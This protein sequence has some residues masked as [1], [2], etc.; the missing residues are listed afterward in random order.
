M[1]PLLIVS[2]ATLAMLL[3]SKALAADCI[4]T[5]PADFGAVPDDDNPDTRQLQAAIDATPSG[6]TLCLPRGHLRVQR[7]GAGAWNR[8]AAVSTHHKGLSVIGVPGESFVD[9][10]GDQGLGSTILWSID[11]GAENITFDGVTLT[12]TGAWNTDEQTH[13]WATTG[14]CSA[15][16]GTC[17][18]IRNLTIRNSVC[19]HP[20][21][22]TRRGDCIRLLGNDL[23]T[24]VFSVLI[25][26]NKLDGARSGVEL[27]R[28]L[29]GV[30]IRGNVFNGATADQHID[31]EASG[32]TPG[33]EVRDVVIT[34]NTFVSGPANQ[35]DHD[36]AL[37]SADN[38]EIYGNR[39]S[40]GVALVRSTRVYIH[41]EVIWLNARGI[42]GVIDVTNTC[43]GLHIQNTKLVRSGVSG[44]MVRLMQRNGNTC[45]DVRIED[46]VMVQQTPSFGVYTESSSSLSVL[47]N[48][49]I[50]T[51]PG[52]GVTAVYARGVVAPVTGL[53]V[54]GNVVIGEL[55]ALAALQGSPY[56]IV[57]PQF[58]QNYSVIQLCTGSGCP[59]P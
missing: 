29:R 26:N 49:M 59:R 25:E 47:R 14:V 5:D 21:G 12:S 37:T 35:G 52:V 2:V 32:V 1:R 7:A 44:P 55:P 48:S 27:Q 56:P 31:G 53:R 22:A 19:I 58:T 42:L 40:R 9:L 46:N 8:F 24:L 50:W 57:L 11:G 28:G 10:V 34:G 3:E 38:V 39:M 20:R 23:N 16:L 45:D 43:T 17:T 36:I 13:L 51:V 33:L 6:G 15:A 30:V 54:D 41:D 18:P 4:G